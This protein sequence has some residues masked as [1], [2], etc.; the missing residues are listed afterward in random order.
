MVL[1]VTVLVASMLPWSP[2]FCMEEAE[3][4]G[5]AQLLL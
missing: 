4:D 1:I 5:K 3:E 2:L